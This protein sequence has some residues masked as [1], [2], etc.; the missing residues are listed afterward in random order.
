VDSDGPS[1]NADFATL[2]ATEDLPELMAVAGAIGKG[3]KIWALLRPLDPKLQAIL[4]GREHERMDSLA[5]SQIARIHFPVGGG[6]F[7]ATAP[8]AKVLLGLLQY[9]VDW[10]METSALFPVWE[11]GTLIAVVGATEPAER[12]EIS[13]TALV[14]SVG[15]AMRR[16]HQLAELRQEV[17]GAK[18]LLQHQAKSIVLARPGG[19]IMHGT[20]GG[21]AVLQRLRSLS[22]LPQDKQEAMLPSVLRNAIEREARHIVIEDLQVHFCELPNPGVTTATELVSI[23]FSRRIQNKPAQASIPMADLTP[24]EKRVLPLLLEGLRN[25]EIAE[26][27][28]SSIHTVKHHVSSILAKARCSDRLLLVA[29]A[30]QPVEGTAAK[31]VVAPLLEGGFLPPSMTQSKAINTA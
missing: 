1:F 18:S 28:N 30:G 23:Q 4:F 7:P 2:Y 12:N 10:T 21:M 27:L 9:Q 24:A 14:H 26:K 22:S 20:E 13:P 19:K 15:L 31:K 17:E 25:K 6:V 29:K 16:L 11:G 8:W 5:A 3:S